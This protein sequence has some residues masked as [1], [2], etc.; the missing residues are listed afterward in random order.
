MYEICSTLFKGTYDKQL[1]ESH[2]ELTVSQH[3]YVLDCPLS[4]KCCPLNEHTSMKILSAKN[5]LWNM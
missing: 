1:E 5:L 4:C 2:D 3:P